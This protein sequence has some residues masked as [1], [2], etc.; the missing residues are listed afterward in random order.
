ML[1]ASEI[2]AMTATIQASLDQSLPLYRVTETQD[3]SGHT[4]ETYPN[5][6]TLTLACNIFKPS[7]EILTTYADVIA[8]KRALMLRYMPA[9][10]VREGDRIVYQSLNWRVQPL[11][12]AESYTFAN[13]VLIITI[14]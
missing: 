3:V 11:E 6:P 13:D 9:Q 2:T 7:A 10:D 8:G 1:S 12:T 5:T 4:V 14:T